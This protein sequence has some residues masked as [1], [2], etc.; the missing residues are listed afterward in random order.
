MQSNSNSGNIC[1]V[2]SACCLPGSRKSAFH[3]L[4]QGILCW[5]QKA[6][7]TGRK[8][9]ASDLNPKPEVSKAPQLWLSPKLFIEFKQH[10]MMTLRGEVL[11]GNTSGSESRSSHSSSFIW[12]WVAAPSHSLLLALHSLWRWGGGWDTQDSQDVV[13]GFIYFHQSYI[14]SATFPSRNHQYFRTIAQPRVA[15][16]APSVSERQLPVKKFT[17]E[18]LMPNNLEPSL[19]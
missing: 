1:Q 13:E 3:S 19:L 9:Q 15:E 16:I 11:P 4:S 10:T 14:S 2:L 17:T 8:Q 7:H 12:V 5:T 18:N 6:D